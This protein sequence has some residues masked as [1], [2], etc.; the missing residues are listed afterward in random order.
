M[1]S[2]TRLNLC[3]RIADIIR[4][5]CWAFLTLRMEVSLKKV[6]ELSLLC[7]FGGGTQDVRVRST[8]P[9]TASSSGDSSV[10]LLISATGL[11]AL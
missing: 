8:S 3:R 7:F 4:G 1:Q 9:G 6:H 10:Y 5:K 2:R 11:S